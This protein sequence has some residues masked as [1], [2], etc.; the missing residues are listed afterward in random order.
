[1]KKSIKRI[2]NNK[3]FQAFATLSFLSLLLTTSVFAAPGDPKIITG[4]PNLIDKLQIW[5]YG[6]IPATTG[7]KVAW[8]AYMKS[9]ADGEGGEVA[10]NNKSMKRTA[11][12]GAIALSANAIVDI[13]FFYLT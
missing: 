12:W 8:H 1:M 11:I 2:M 6:I 4:V 10:A 13:V 9:L 5:L 7:L 3:T